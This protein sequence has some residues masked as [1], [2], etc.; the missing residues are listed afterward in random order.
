[1]FIVASFQRQWCGALYAEHC[2]AECLPIIN[3]GEWRHAPSKRKAMLDMWTIRRHKGRFDGLKIAWSF[4]DKIC[5]HVWQRS[6]LPTADD[7][8]R[9]AIYV[10][11]DQQH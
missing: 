11:L 5:I 4:G 2:N 6:Q 9:L 10:W 8:R 7:V 3:A 1:M